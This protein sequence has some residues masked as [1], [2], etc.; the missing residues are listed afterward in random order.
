MCWKFCMYILLRCLISH[1]ACVQFHYVSWQHMKLVTRTASR[2][3]T[4]F[5]IR[6]IV[7]GNLGG[8]NVRRRTMLY[9]FG[10]ESG[11][12]VC[13]HPG[14]NC[15]SP[16]RVSPGETFH[17]LLFSLLAVRKAL[18]SRGIPLHWHE[19]SRHK[20]SSCPAK[21]WSCCF[22]A[23]VFGWILSWNHHLPN[24]P[25]SR[26]LRS[27]FWCAQD[28]L[29]RLQHL[30]RWWVC[31][32][33]SELRALDLE[34]HRLYLCPSFWLAECTSE[35]LPGL[36]GKTLPQ[37]RI[38]QDWNWCLE[39]VLQERIDRKLNRDFLSLKPKE[40]IDVAVWLLSVYIWSKTGS[41][42]K[43]HLDSC[44]S[45]QNYLGGTNRS[46][47]SVLKVHCHSKTAFS[48]LFKTVRTV[49]SFSFWQTVLE[50]AMN[51]S[52][53]LPH[54]QQTHGEGGPNPDL[55]A[56]HSVAANMPPI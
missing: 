47:K 12:V 3:Y 16:T 28:F 46:V 43:V 23:P 24:S 39:S 53:G 27:H 33:G 48:L 36:I 38:Q 9:S 22:F 30:L 34:T 41:G 50:G 20:I 6:E 17:L 8:R 4:V 44:C 21:A 14:L 13:E 7:L 32:T 11:F 40:V 10:W 5:R 18:C 54:W 42:S 45:F 49:D 2:I 37:S 55:I 15:L 25:E 35:I 31:R 26:R 52:E 29:S 1:L 56:W 51:N 19:T